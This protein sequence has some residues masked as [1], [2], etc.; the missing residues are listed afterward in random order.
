[1][2]IDTLKYNTMEGEIIPIDDI[3]VDKYI[4]PYILTEEESRLKETIWK[5]QNADYLRR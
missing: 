3:D 2:T 1:M 4:N 5:S